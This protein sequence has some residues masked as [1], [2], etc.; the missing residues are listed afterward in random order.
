[1]KEE[2]GM[3]R[4]ERVI[5]KTTGRQRLMDGKGRG[6]TDWNQDLITWN[7]T[8]WIVRRMVGRIDRWKGGR[9]EEW[10]CGWVCGW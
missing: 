9:E 7:E 8:E 2:E 3:R 6:L 10:K 4:G 5:G 1:M